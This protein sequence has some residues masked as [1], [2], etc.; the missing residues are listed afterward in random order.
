MK[1]ALIILLF[2]F[3]SFGQDITRLEEKKQATE[4]A[5]THLQ[6]MQNGFL[7]VRLDDKKKEIDYYL[8]FQNFDE[9]KKI[10]RQ[11]DNINEQIRLAF[12]KY[13]TLCP[14]YY[15]NMSDSRSLLDKK[16]SEVII[17]DAL[18][19][20]VSNVDLATSKFYIAEFGVANQ[21]EVTNDENVNEGEYNEKMALSALVIRTSELLELRDPFPYF[22]RYNSMG[23]L[24]SRYL[25]PVKKMQDKLTAFGAY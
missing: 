18:E 14:V 8:K 22:V 9:A 12:T 7:L 10:K 21:D 15:F 4:T 5:K 20:T 13:F 3:H 19:Q 17:F 24:K 16:Y 1:I 25:T 2:S 6:E 23:G 11:Q